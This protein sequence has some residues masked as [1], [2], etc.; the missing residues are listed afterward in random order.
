MS[1]S[2]A[3]VNRC[4]DLAR[5]AKIHRPCEGC[6]PY[7]F[8]NSVPDRTIADKLKCLYFRNFE[9]AYRILHISSSQDD[10]E[11]YWTD[12]KAVEDG[13]VVSIFLIMAIGTCFYE[14]HAY[15]AGLR[16][17]VSRWIDAVCQGHVS[18]HGV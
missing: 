17:N 11:Q 6:L 10:Y 8:K 16:S 4:K 7:E 5:K 18:Y 12:P 9:S 14:G 15:E 13:F 3:L 2:L 1:E